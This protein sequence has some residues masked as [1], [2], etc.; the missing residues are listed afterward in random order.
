M[1]TGQGRGHRGAGLRQNPP[2]YLSGLQSH[3]FLFVRLGKSY[4]R[5]RTN[6]K[7]VFRTRYFQYWSKNTKTFCFRCFLC[8]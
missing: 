5:Q 7:T 2:C 3:R 1:Q 4:S 8:P 6:I